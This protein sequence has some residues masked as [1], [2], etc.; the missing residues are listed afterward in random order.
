MLLEDENPNDQPIDL[1]KECKLLLRNPW[2]V[3]LKCIERSG[4]QAADAMVI[5]LPVIGRNG[6]GGEIFRESPPE[7]ILPIL[8]ADV[9]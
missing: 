1:I 5:F 7:W 8:A 4:N 2:I 3:E 6:E 9:I